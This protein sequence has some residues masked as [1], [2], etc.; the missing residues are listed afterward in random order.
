M[1]YI[2]M[3]KFSLR[4]LL[5]KTSDFTAHANGFEISPKALRYM[6]LKVSEAYKVEYQR[7][8]ERVRDAKWRYMDET[9]MGSR[10]RTGSS[11]SS[12]HPTMTCWR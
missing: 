8:L 6:I 3:L 9:G 12:E 4:G 1:T 2:T 10:A 7:I 5:R 11:G